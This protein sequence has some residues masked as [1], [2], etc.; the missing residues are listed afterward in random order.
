MALQEQG[1]IQFLLD[2]FNMQKLQTKSE[3]DFTLDAVKLSGVMLYQNRRFAF[4][5]PF[6]L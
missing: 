5:C 2:L 6:E 4:K 3:Q 1:E